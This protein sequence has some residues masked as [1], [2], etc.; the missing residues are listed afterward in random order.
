M[1]RLPRVEVRGSPL[2]AT[3]GAL[4]EAL[5]GRAEVPFDEFAAALR[6]VDREIQRVRYP[7]GRETS[8][9][10]RFGELAKRLGLG[11]PE[12]PELLTGVHMG[13]LRSTAETP[14]HH[15]EV[16]ASLRRHVPVGLCS[17]FTHSP[18]ALGILDESGLAPHLDPVVISVDVGLRKPRREIFD[19][20]LA[21]LGT[22]PEETLHVGD[23]LDAD[24]AG[25]AARG[26]ETAWLRRRVRDPE[27]ALRSY[28]GPPP[29]H[30][31][32]D[33]SEL[34]ALVGGS[35]GATR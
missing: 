5:A 17:N 32:D 35:A 20:V 34:V 6:E 15:V 4:H 33:L 24:V 1:D 29:D 16:L 10:V 26:F 9:P 31:L 28:R 18:T 13:L 25:A 12:I 22:A 19:A 21:G 8:T 30:V 7:E 11:D 23:N 2:H 3:T 14:D 27:K